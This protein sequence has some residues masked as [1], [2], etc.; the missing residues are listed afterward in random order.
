MML[1]QQLKPYSNIKFFFEKPINEKEFNE[2]I[3][4]LKK[5]EIKSANPQLFIP[6]MIEKNKINYS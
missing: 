2:I 1:K 3:Y 6:K 4:E 5:I